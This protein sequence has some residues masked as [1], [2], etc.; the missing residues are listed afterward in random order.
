MTLSIEQ[1]LNILES[2]EQIKELRARYAWLITRGKIE[3]VLAL[4]TEDAIFESWAKDRRHHVQG[5]AALGALMMAA[6]MRRPCTA[7]PLIHNDII[8]I[9][10]DRATGTCVMQTP[11]GPNQPDGFTGYYHDVMRREQNGWLFA[12]RRFYLYQPFFEEP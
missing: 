9:D 5:R 7:V 4:F 6:D 11:V 12:E 3:E 2:R 1:R 8:E 10:G